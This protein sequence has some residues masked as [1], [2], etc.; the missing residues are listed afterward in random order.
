MQCLENNWNR[1]ESSGGEVRS[2]KRS[3]VINT[4]H[5]SVTQRSWAQPRCSLFQTIAKCL[6]SRCSKHVNVSRNELWG[7]FVLPADTQLQGKKREELSPPPPGLPA[8]WHMSHWTE[9]PLVLKSPNRWRFSSTVKC[10]SCGALRRGACHR[11]AHVL[12]H[13]PPSLRTYLCHLPSSRET[14]LLT[15]CSRLSVYRHPSTYQPMAAVILAPLTSPCPLRCV[16]QD[17]SVAGSSNNREQAGRRTDR[18]RRRLPRGCLTLCPPL[19]Q[20]LL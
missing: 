7:I 5:N 2:A 10:D 14:K 15:S 6:A 3:G 11:S 12:S 13:P 19:A 16:W 9:R 18:Q 1:V 4:M 17:P 8:C 20:S